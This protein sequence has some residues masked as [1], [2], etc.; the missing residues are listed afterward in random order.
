MAKHIWNT[1]QDLEEIKHIYTTVRFPG[2]TGTPVLEDNV[3]VTSVSRTAVGE[4]TLTLDEAYNEV[5]EAEVNVSCAATAS[6]MTAVHMASSNPRTPT[7]VLR[8]V[9]HANTVADPVA[10]S[11]LFHLALR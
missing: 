3:G 9:N 5:V 6:G 8:L 4:L 7:V 11:G 2:G 10:C 1:P